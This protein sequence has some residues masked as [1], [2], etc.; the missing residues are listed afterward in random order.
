MSHLSII[1]PDCFFA[2]VKKASGQKNRL[3][4]E[5]MAQGLYNHATVPVSEEDK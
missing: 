3:A 4:M 1:L 5:L 2:Q